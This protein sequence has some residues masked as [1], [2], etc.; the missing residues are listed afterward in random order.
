MASAANRPLSD[1]VL[2]TKIKLSN[3]QNTV[4]AAT[5]GIFAQKGVIGRH[6]SKWAYGVDH[7]TREKAPSKGRYRLSDA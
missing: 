3:T 1:A 6:L 2:P 5:P 7:R 4:N